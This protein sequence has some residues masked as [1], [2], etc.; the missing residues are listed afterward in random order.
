MWNWDV[1]GNSE[2][3]FAD[4]DALKPWQPG[5]FEAVLSGDNDYENNPIRVKDMQAWQDYN[6]ATSAQTNTPAPPSPFDN[7]VG[8]I[9]S[10][11]GL[12]VPDPLP[13]NQ[14]YSP[15]GFSADSIADRFQV[16]A[17]QAYS[18]SGF[19][20]QNIA[21]R[22]QDPGQQGQTYY[23][24]PLP[25]FQPQSSFQAPTFNQGLMQML[26]QVPEADLTGLLTGYFNK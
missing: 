17:N 5:E 26:G 13:V 19:N 9:P 10:G 23:A 21:N 7:G 3:G 25:T 15:F 2:L 6:A 14:T 16:P 12:T 24:A 20:A 11:T 8:S 4:P 22:F 18:P 1:I